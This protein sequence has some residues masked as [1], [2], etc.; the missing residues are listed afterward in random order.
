MFQYFLCLLDG[1]KRSVELADVPVL[2][3][4][5]HGH[6]GLH[7]LELLF[8]LHRGGFARR[9]AMWDW[10]VS[11]ARELM[12]GFGLLGQDTLEEGVAAG[13]LLR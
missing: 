7:Y 5:L 4:D 6:A 11:G 12:R 2:E 3:G 8:G 10:F 9:R 13:P 1:V